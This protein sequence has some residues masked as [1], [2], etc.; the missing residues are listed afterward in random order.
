MAVNQE[1]T[2]MPKGVTIMRTLIIALWKKGMTVFLRIDHSE[3]VHGTL[4]GRFTAIKKV[5]KEV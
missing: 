2:S 5:A 1:Y 4:K 3:G